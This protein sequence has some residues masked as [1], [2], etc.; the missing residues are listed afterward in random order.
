VRDRATVFAW[1]VRLFVLA[2][3]AAV[4]CGCNGVQ[5]ALA[6]EGAEAE[7]VWLL[8]WIMSVGGFAIL[9]AVV[10]L[11]VAAVVKRP[12]WIG[13]EAL[14]IGGGLVFPAITLSAL[15]VYG[16]MLMNAAARPAGEG[17]PLQLSVRGEQ[18]WWR[19]T[20]NTGD[21]KRVESAN[22]IRIPVGR[23]VRIELTSADV[24]HSL[25][26]PK[27][28]GKL[29]MIPGRTNVLNITANS[30]GVSRG[31]CAEYCGGAHALMS[32]YVVASPPEE[33]ATWFE[34]EGAPA[35][36]DSDPDAIAGQMLFLSHGCGGC[37]T[38]RGTSANGTIGPDLTHVGGRMSL[39]AAA[40]PNDEAA[41]ARW[42]VDN[43][44]IKPRNRMP[45]FGIFG[46]AEL[47]S[48]SRYL[49]GLK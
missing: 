8:F 20:Y 22:E 27:L 25:W 10:A 44:H 6:P 38:I 36:A 42:I 41:I 13:S 11:T 31:Q 33:F 16:L 19:V 29:D 40:L 43:Q 30:P 48:L 12:A 15:L 34:R 3:A 28:A 46:K 23:T 7:R 17:A 37:H 1:T 2:G 35:R 14:I 5:S 4:L 39:A 18:W 32:F 26:I 21:G 49:S 47:A 45:P 24:I 9:A